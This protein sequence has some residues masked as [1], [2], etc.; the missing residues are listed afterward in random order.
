MAVK[1]VSFWDAFSFVHARTAS[2]T[3]YLSMHIC[4]K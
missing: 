3:N 1:P 2:T 4:H